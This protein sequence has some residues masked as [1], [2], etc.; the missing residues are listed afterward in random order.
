MPIP[1][2]TEAQAGRADLKPVVQFLFKHFGWLA[3][4]S[5]EINQET[6]L[7]AKKLVQFVQHCVSYR[8]TFDHLAAVG[9]ARLVI[10]QVFRE[11]DVNWAT[12]AAMVVDLQALYSAAMAEDVWIRS[13]MASDL[14][15]ASTVGLDPQNNLTEAV[16]ML[17]KSQEFATRMSN[18]RALFGPKG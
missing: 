6:E 14:Q 13:N 8:E 10:E 7:N 1:Y 3:R 18:F 2:P 12:R 15:T 11:H 16:K 4:L 5:D 17:P 9:G